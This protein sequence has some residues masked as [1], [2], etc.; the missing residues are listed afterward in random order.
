ME[1]EDDLKDTPSLIPRVESTSSILESA[2]AHES[3]AADQLA[4]EIYGE[5]PTTKAIALLIFITHDPLRLLYLLYHG[6]Y[7]TYFFSLVALLC[8]AILLTLIF[9]MG[10][11]TFSRCRDSAAAREKELKKKVEALQDSIEQLQLTLVA[12]EKSTG[13]NSNDGKHLMQP[14]VFHAGDKVFVRDRGSDEN[15]E[16]GRGIV[17]GFNAETGATMVTI[18]GWEE[19]YEWDEIR[20]RVDDNQV[21]DGTDI[22]I[23]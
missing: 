20:I 2:S 18:E 7:L 17:S 3:C 21:N 6:G 8:P 11:R 19:A 16:W 4:A 12:K 22:T 10:I 13:D 23:S 14:A 15:E 1:V 9:I 5:N